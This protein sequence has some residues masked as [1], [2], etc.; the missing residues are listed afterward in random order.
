MEIN[1]NEEGPNE[2][3]DLNYEKLSDLKYFGTTLS[4]K[5]DWF[6]EISIRINKAQKSSDTMTTF[7]IFKILSI[8]TK[9]RLYV[10][11]TRFSCMA[12]KL[13]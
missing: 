9:V 3:E 6:K 2:M 11:I 8:K 5:K 1:E 7:L 4:M 10:T 13:R 12:R